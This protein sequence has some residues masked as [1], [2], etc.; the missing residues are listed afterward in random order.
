MAIYWMTEAIP[1]A[2]TALIPFALMP[3]LGILEASEI[4]G[5][6]ITVKLFKSFE[7]IVKL[8]L[9]NTLL[10]INILNLVVHFKE[11][12]LVSVYG[13]NNGI[14]HAQ[15]VEHI[16]KSARN[17]QWKSVTLYSFLKQTVVLLSPKCR[18]TDQAIGLR[19]FPTVSYNFF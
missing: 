4:A 19:I 2:A 10:Y 3:W 5:N 1:M 14:K 15:A 18:P 16:R 13:V 8:H 7:N 9:Q 17:L 6:Y 12:I 11:V